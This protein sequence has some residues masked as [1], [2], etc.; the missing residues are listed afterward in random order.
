MA[1]LTYLTSKWMIQKT[2]S[3]DPP[4]IYCKT[5]MVTIA[6]FLKR[7]MECISW[8]KKKGEEKK[9]VEM[10]EEKKLVFFQDFLGF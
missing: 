6:V 3:K 7:N 8:T 4:G 5:I 1:E 2:G 9:K 10:R